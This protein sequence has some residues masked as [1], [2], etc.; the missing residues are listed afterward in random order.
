MDKKIEHWDDCLQFSIDIYDRA[1]LILYNGGCEER[2]KIDDTLEK[3]Y[4]A[5]VDGGGD[6]LSSK[7]CEEYLLRGLDELGL[8][9]KA[10]Y[11]G[12]ER[13]D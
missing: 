6:E 2:E 1:L 13:D 3:R 7:P 11:I 10:V 4:S 5:W 12:G 8:D 9:Y